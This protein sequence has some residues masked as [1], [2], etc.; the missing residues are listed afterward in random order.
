MPGLG[1]IV[2]VAAVLAGGTIGLLLKKILS[3]RLTDMI[4]QGLGLAVLIVGLSGV[5]TSALSLSDSGLVFNY[6]LFMILSLAV[7]ALLG[8]LFRIED[9]VESLSGKLGGMFK[10]SNSSLFAEGFMSATLLFTVGA[11]AIVGSLEDGINRN[12]DILFV[13]SALDFI[14]AMVF[15]GAFGAGV[16]L[17][18][19]PVGIYQGILTVLALFLSKILTDTVI[20]QMTLIGSVLIVG[21]SLN[22]LKIA[23]IK[24]SNLLPAIFI[25]LIYYAFSVVFGL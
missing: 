6:L 20:S 24:V 13:K 14:S 21:L 11:M 5:F 10:S 18:A 9:H 17:S 1:T 4:T 2:N 25:P 15:A 8:E 23:K 22:M 3:E 12:T 16:L 7:G 19:I